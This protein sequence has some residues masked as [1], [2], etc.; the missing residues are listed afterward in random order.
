MASRSV[1]LSRVAGVDGQHAAGDVAAA[2]TQEVFDHAGDIV[3]LRQPT[4]GA[5]A[6]DTLALIFRKALRQFGIDETR[7]NRIDGDP[8][9]A[10][11]ARQRSGEA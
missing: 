2:V 7:R 8:E 6:G 1:S 9:L 5:A 3:G 11:L 4:Q 10:D